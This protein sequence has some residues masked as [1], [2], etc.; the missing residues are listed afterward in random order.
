VSI[1]QLLIDNRDF[2]LSLDHGDPV[3]RAADAMVIRILRDDLE[4]PREHLTMAQ[5]NVVNRI[6]ETATPIIT[7]PSRAL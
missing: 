5:L 3:R 7:Y 1:R 4:R 2:I 6:L